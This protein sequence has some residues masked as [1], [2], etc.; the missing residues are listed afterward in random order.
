MLERVKQI[1]PQESETS[2]MVSYEIDEAR[3]MRACNAL[4]S[5]RAIGFF[6]NYVAAATIGVFGLIAVML[7]VPGWCAYLLI[8]CALLIVGMDILRGR[9]WRKYYRG[10]EKYRAPITAFVG[11]E[12]VGV[13]SAEGLHVQPWDVFQSF[14]RTDEFLFLILDQRQF[15]VIP[16]EAF[17]S[18]RDANAFEEVLVDHLPRMP[19]R[20]F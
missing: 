6:G 18:L 19:R 8:A 3:F 20:Y 5:Y 2:V 16:L 14:V 15:S 12:G 10:L 7:G 13:D 9:L 1:D 11:K 17:D 4:W